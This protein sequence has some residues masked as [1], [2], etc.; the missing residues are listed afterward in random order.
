MLHCAISTVGYIPHTPFDR[1][2]LSICGF[3]RP[4]LLET[5]SQQGSMVNPL[6]IRGREPPCS[7]PRLLG[8]LIDSLFWDP[9]HRLV[10]SPGCGP[11]CPQDP[12]GLVSPDSFL[13]KYLIAFNCRWGD[14]AVGPVVH[15]FTIGRNGCGASRH[16][17]CNVS[18][19]GPDRCSPFH[20]ISTATSLDR[21]RD[22]K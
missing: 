11:R 4:P 1:E 3:C 13:G 17:G 14:C 2:H 18:W 19:S 7:A 10:V 20:G 12:I 6:R 15:T 22:G 8:F 21:M 5:W 9:S 16:I